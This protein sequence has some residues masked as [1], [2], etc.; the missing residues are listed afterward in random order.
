MKAYGEEELRIGG[1]IVMWPIRAILFQ[2]DTKCPQ[3]RGSIL[4]EHINNPDHMSR[5]RAIDTQSSSDEISMH[6][7]Q[8]QNRTLKRFYSSHVLETTLYFD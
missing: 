7:S 3:E 8:E 6:N 2:D 1:L 5:S 4:G